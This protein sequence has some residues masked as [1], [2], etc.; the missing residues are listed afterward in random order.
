MQRATRHA[1]HATSIV[2]VL[3]ATMVLW[4][5][6]GGPPTYILTTYDFSLI[7]KVAV[8]PLQNF[9]GGDPKA[10]DRVR[11]LVVTEILAVGVLDVIE[12]GE[13]NN[14]L[15]RQRIESIS[16]LSAEDYK[17]LG[18]ALGVEALVMGSVDT[19]ERINVAG[20]FFG[21]VTVTLMA[22]DTATGRVIWSA[23]GSGGGVGVMGRLFGVGGDTMTEASQEAVR[24]AVATLFE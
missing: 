17:K 18:V 10:A 5:C 20:S 22:V 12:P 1:P 3:F 14:V 7:Q 2:V 9:S 24:K 15:V 19:Y 23:N 21:E 13:V 4:G 16:S 8:L 6:R 11:N